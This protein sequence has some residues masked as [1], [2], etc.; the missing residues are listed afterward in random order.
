M[1]LRCH[2]WI[3]ALLIL[4]FAPLTSANQPAVPESDKP[5]Q[6]LLNDWTSQLVLARVT[7]QVL[8]SMGYNV[9]YVNKTSNAQWGSLKLGLSH[10][11]VEVWEGTMSKMFQR[12]IDAGAIV[13]AGTHDAITREEWWY[14]LYVEELCPGLPD[15]QA[16][17]KCSDLFVDPRTAPQ[18][19]YLGGPWEKPDAARIRALGMDFKAIT[20]AQGDDLWV[21]L[22]RAT[23][24]QRPIVLFNWT[25]N[26]VEAKYPGR[27]IEFPDYHPDCETKPG[28][29]TNPRFLHDC[30]NPKKGWLKKVAWK[31]MPDTWPC[32]YETLQNINFSN[33]MIAE[34]ASMVDVDGLSYEAAADKWV[35]DNQMVWSEWI[36]P[37]CQ[38]EQ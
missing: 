11:Q 21:E 14:P 35:V 6:V 1:T 28:W 36:P 30:G 23:I 9:G 32:A 15:W 33:A 8:Q 2:N 4:I 29:G 3:A 17:K 19:M 12:M 26:W 34:L 18:G 16:L 10:I 22:K 27:F 24:E 7:G 25:P 5:I 31:G 20:V 38:I 37:H 13:D